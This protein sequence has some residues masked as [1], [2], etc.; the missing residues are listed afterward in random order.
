LHSV[1]NFFL[2]RAVNLF[3]GSGT[4]IFWRWPSPQ[5]FTYLSKFLGIRNNFEV[6]GSNHL[7]YAKSSQDIGVLAPAFPISFLVYSSAFE[8][9]ELMCKSLLSSFKITDLRSR[10]ILGR[11]SSRHFFKF[12]KIQDRLSCWAN[13][14]RKATKASAPFVKFSRILLMDIM[15]LDTGFFA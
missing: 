15:K 14:D 6:P 3:Q 10:C 1:L 11:S 4:T 7:I 13:P 5:N 8:L 9:K 12:R 2:P